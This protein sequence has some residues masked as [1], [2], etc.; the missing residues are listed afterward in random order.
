VKYSLYTTIFWLLKFEE[1]P[2]CRL[3]TQSG[4][5]ERTR[6]TAETRLG[7][8]APRPPAARA[9]WVGWVLS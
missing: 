9:G 4:E 5:R 3:Q 7:V 2:D 8:S 6:E 1:Y